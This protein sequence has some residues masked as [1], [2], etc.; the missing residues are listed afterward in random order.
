MWKEKVV[1]KLNVLS[2]HLSVIH[3]NLRIAGFRIEMWT[4]DL[5]LIKEEHYLPSFDIPWKV[6]ANALSGNYDTLESK[7]TEH[8]AEGKS[9]KVIYTSSLS[10]KLLSVRSFGTQPC[11]PGL[12]TATSTRKCSTGYSVWRDSVQS[13]TTR[14]DVKGKS[15]YIATKY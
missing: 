12:E 14:K 10:L 13:E 4:R 15:I 7:Y 8:F 2:Q 11:T 5:L 6:K 9:S 1:I 3:E